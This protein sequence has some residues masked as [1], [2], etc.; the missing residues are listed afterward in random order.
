MEKLG[1]IGGLGPAATVQ[2]MGRIIDFTKADCDQEHLDITVLCRPQT[3]DR[4]AY[5][6]GKPG[7]PSFVEPMQ[8]A[9]R[10]LRDAGCTV[11]LT[12]CNTAHSKL[13]EIAQAVPDCRFVSMPGETAKYAAQL[14]CTRVG[15]LATDG[16]KAAGV[17]DS[18]LE[19]AGVRP[20]WPDEEGQ[21]EVMSVIYDDVKAGKCLDPN[22]TLA[23]CNRLI[24][25][26]ADGIILGC[27]ELSVLGIRPWYAGVPVIDAL[28]VAAWRSVQEC[29]AP[30]RFQ[31][32]PEKPAN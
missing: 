23:Q 15:V 7:A 25:Q 29:G 18:A 31:P 16:A 2:L 20:M 12:P 19:A 5:L 11:L 24:A 32:V 6:L 10:D 14:G 26:G 13:D 30:A 17:Y 9:A 28:D 8:Q 3:P 22:R 1:I 4:T 21:R 27:T